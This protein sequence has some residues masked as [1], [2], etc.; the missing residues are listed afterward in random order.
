[1]HNWL[2]VVR[3]TRKNAS[4]EFAPENVTFVGYMSEEEKRRRLGEA[5]AVIFNAMNEDFGIVPVEAFAS[6]TPVLGVADG[7]T[8]YQILDGENGLLHEP[9]ARSIRQ[10][11]ERF[12]RDGVA[13][14]TTELEEFSKRFSFERFRKRVQEVVENVTKSA[15]IEPLRDVSKQ[16]SSPAILGKE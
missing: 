8:K 16:R 1:M 5:R 10:N 4:N 13:W 11:I 3:A 6:G 12:E 15:A 7:Y 9:D 14:S 2:L